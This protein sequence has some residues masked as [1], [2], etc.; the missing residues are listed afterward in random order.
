MS[1]V[2][3]L[4]SV[5]AAFEFR[6]LHWR[7][8][9]GALA[10]AAA[11]ATLSTAGDISGRTTLGTVGEI[12]HLVAALIGYAALMRIAF[13]DEHAGEA[14]FQPGPR[15]IQWGRPEWRLIGVGLLMVFAFIVFACLA[16]FLVFLI[17]VVSGA[18][19]LQPGTD[20]ATFA[21]AIGPGGQA[22]LSLVIIGSLLGVLYASV[23]L[24]LAPAATIA[25]REVQV[26]STWSL[27]KGQFWRIFLATLLIGLPAIAASLLLGLLLAVL[28]EPT[29]P[30]EAYR[31]SLPL[32]L[33]MSVVPGL[34]VGFWVVP[35]SA[36]LTAYLY[37]GLRPPPERVAEVFGGPDFPTP[38]N[39]A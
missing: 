29:G 2:P 34:I 25:R 35:L 22:A 4:Q 26:F 32:A 10:L 31:A 39:P 37:R 21:E 23:R 36:G 14:E 16:I 18:G 5:R 20:P 17:T 13:A 30:N 6:R 27:T 1:N 15:G 8:A 24:S 7:E 33:A 11:G 12:V 19:A 38:S 3:V 28:G 9:V